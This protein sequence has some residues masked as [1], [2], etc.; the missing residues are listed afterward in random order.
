MSSDSAG[1]A[2]GEV[3]GGGVGWRGGRM[4]C[5]GS[6]HLLEALLDLL[7]Q[8]LLS[9]AHLQVGLAH[10]RRVQGL[11]RW[12]LCAGASLLRFLVGE[13]VWCFAVG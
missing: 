12:G 7:E 2:E 3:G 11:R 4:V 9:Y 1:W 5:G 6:A 8:P 13:S 10:L